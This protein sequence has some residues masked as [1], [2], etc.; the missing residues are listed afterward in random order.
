MRRS[1]RIKLQA[2]DNEGSNSDCE[3]LFG[4]DENFNPRFMGSK[5]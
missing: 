3:L 1:L 5:F 4:D 2:K